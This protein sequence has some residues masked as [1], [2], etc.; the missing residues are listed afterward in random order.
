MNTTPQS[1]LTELQQRVSELFRNS[2]AADIERNLKAMLAQTFQRVDLVTRDE[3]DAQLE[4][5]SR[6]QERIA[7]LEQRL[8]AEAPGASASEGGAAQAGTTSDGSEAAVSHPAGAR[9]AG[10]IAMPG[11]GPTT[12]DDPGPVI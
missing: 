10:P 11:P 2:P 3:F 1:L 5:M 7:T 4:R 8:D 6:L 9:D 12:P